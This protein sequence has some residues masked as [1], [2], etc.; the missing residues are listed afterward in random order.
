M[1]VAMSFNNVAC[2]ASAH[3]ILRVEHRGTIHQACCEIDVLVS[4]PQHVVWTKPY[5]DHDRYSFEELISNDMSTPCC[6]TSIC[7]CF[8]GEDESKQVAH[9]QRRSCVA[10]ATNADPAQC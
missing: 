3:A 6:P 4:Y 10:K 2:V 9:A 7:D 8:M 5:F 1:T